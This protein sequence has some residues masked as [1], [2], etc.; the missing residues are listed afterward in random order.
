MSDHYSD[1]FNLQKEKLLGVLESL[2]ESISYHKNNTNSEQPELV[3]I[4]HRMA[5]VSVSLFTVRLLQ[6]LLPVEKVSNNFSC[7]LKMTC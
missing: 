5:F 7:T 1:Y 2:G 6:A 4:H 3:L